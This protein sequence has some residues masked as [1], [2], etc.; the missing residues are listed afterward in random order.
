MVVM[1]IVVWSSYPSYAEISGSYKY[2]ILDD[3]TVNITDYTGT[4]SELVIPST[5]EEKQI[6]SIE[7]YGFYKCSS[8]HTIEV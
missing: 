6:T 5:I 8:L 1:S 2:K 4:E 7:A 3:G